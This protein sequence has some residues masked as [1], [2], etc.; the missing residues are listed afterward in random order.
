MTRI[1]INEIKNIE[2]K[3][4]ALKDDDALY[5]CENGE[6]K[7]VVLTADFFDL[8]DSY[9]YIFDEEKRNNDNVKMIVDNN[10]GEISY[11]EYETL[12]KQLIDVFDK[13]FKPKA[14]KLN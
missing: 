3:L 13:T 11:D 4:H 12:R 1:D 2:N 10:I 14:E 6:S 9:R 7:Y 8:L 5:V